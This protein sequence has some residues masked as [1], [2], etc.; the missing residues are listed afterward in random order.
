L[1]Y[2][3]G[4]AQCHKA[5]ELDENLIMSNGVHWEVLYIQHPDLESS[6]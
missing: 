1:V 3:E 4:Y 5:D 6:D 2:G